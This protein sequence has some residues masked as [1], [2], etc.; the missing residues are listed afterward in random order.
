MAATQTVA[1]RADLRNTDNIKLLQVPRHGVVTLCGYGIKVHVDRGH[2]ILEDGM[3][4]DRLHGRLPRV[5]HGLRRL[6]I[7]GADGF[8]S[9]AALRWLADQDAAFVM[10]ERDGSVLASTGPVRPSDARLRRAQALAFG[11]ETGLRIVR[12]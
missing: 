5:G 11:S 8:V 9:L 12:S 1:Q 6:V 7:I 4:A 2:L 3:G 10:L